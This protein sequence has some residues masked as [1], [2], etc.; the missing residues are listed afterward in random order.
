MISQLFAFEQKLHLHRFKGGGAKTVVQQVQA[1]PV[2]EPPRQ[3][4]AAKNITPGSI[5]RPRNQR[6]LGR[7]G[8]LLAPRDTLEDQ[9]T[10]LL[11]S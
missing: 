10:S 9:I 7:A 6:K 3:G 1:A 2:P 4:D 8:T 5:A 11:G